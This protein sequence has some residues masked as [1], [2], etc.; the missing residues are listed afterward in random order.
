[1]YFVVSAHSW[2]DNRLNDTKRLG[3][4]LTLTFYILMY[5]FFLTY[6]YPT[7]TLWCKSCFICKFELPMNNPWLLEFL[8]NVKYEVYFFVTWAD[9]LLNRLSISR[10]NGG[11]TSRFVLY[12]FL[13][14]IQKT[15][16]LS[17]LSKIN[18][19]IQYCHNKNELSFYY[20]RIFDRLK[21]VVIHS[22]LCR[23]MVV[24][25]VF[26][27]I[28]YQSGFEKHTLSTKTSM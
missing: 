5:I 11:P 27:H 22:F 26:K 15:R 20:K 24:Q 16:I 21:I 12:I 2:P 4:V 3:W 14:F 13:A 9:S 8:Y 25:I 23:S 17:C 6:S 1:M 19:Y 10:A 18:T 28:F 7:P